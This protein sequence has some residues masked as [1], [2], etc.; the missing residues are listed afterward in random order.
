MNKRQML[1]L[2]AGVA[3]LVCWSGTPSARAQEGAPPKA[4]LS[5]MASPG[6][7]AQWQQRLTLGPGDVLNLALLDAPDS[8]RQGVVIGPDGRLSFLQAEDIMAAGLTIDELRAKMNEALGKFYR[9]PATI[10][11]PA[12]YNSKKYFVL[13]AVV[14]K[15]VF[16]LD[17]PTT[18]I[19]AIARAG[20]L[21]TGL[22][23]RN[24]VELADLTHSF[25][26][27]KGQRVP[28]DFERLFQRG[29]LSQNVSL[30]PDDYLYFASANANE[31]YVLG[32]VLNPGVLSFAPKATVISAIT[33]RGGFSERAFK[34]RVLVVRGSLSQPETFVV[35]TS[36]ILAARAPDFKLQQKDIVY[37]SL[38]PW[39]TAA[40]V[41][42]TAA[43][44]F[45]QGFLVQATTTE[46]GPII[47]TPLVK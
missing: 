45:V 41:L 27:R 20:G 42:D 28:V 1:L 40:D 24:T 25:L 17:R 32:E 8:A 12:A 30:E 35:N 23:E 21:E 47:T 11:T 14:N 9:N 37:V 39:T 10:V 7:R 33:S 22:F 36:D 34:S 38:N 44:A 5:A 31:I 46:V 43:R 13:G 4:T 2:S 19:E 18:V 6:K 16:P 15:G 29:D 26:V 3:A